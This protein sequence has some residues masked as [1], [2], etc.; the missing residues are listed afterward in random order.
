MKLKLQLKRLSV[1]IIWDFETIVNQKKT[2]KPCL[3][4]L[5]LCF[6]L[7]ENVFTFFKHYLVFE[8]F[9]PLPVVFRG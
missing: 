1:E 5:N 8:I 2:N 9:K 3:V 4:S 6:K 7:K